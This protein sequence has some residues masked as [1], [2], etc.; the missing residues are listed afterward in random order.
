MQSLHSLENCDCKVGEKRRPRARRGAGPRVLGLLTTGPSQPGSRQLLGLCATPWGKFGSSSNSR[1]NLCRGVWGGG[2]H[3]HWA[4]LVHRRGS[5]A[6][7]PVSSHPHPTRP[8]LFLRLA[9]TWE[10]MARKGSM[11]NPWP[12]PRAPFL[13]LVPRILFLPFS[14][15][16]S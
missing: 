11:N 6:I 3:N 13:A 4:S 16:G 12:L 10:Q 2:F 7:R 14:R 5:T 9:G 15:A 8:P 1:S